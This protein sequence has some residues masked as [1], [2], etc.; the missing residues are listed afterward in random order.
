MKKEGFT[1][2]ELLAVIVILGILAIVIVPTVD[3]SLKDFRKQAYEDQI[4]NIELAAKNWGAD[5]PFDLPENEGD[6]ITVT[7]GS[8]KNGGYVDYRIKNPTTDRYFPN[9][10]LIEVERK[11]KNYEY[12]VIEGS[13]TLEGEYEIDSP[14]LTLKGGSIIY[15]GL[16]ETYEEPGYTARTSSG[17][18]IPDSL[19][20]K[21]IRMNGSEVSSINTDKISTYE[22]EYSVTDRGYTTTVKRQVIVRDMTP[23]VIVVDGH[24]SDF[25]VNHEASSS[26]T[27]PNGTA[28]DNSG[29]AIT[30]TK[31][32]NVI[33]NMVG[34]YKVTYTA[35]DS[36]NN[37]ATLIMTVIVTDTK[38]PT[39]TVSGNPSNWTKNDVTLTINAS[40]SGSGLSTKGAYSFDDGKT[41]Q[42]SNKK[43]FSS[44]QTVHIKVRDNAGNISTR[45]SVVI[46][47][48]D[49]IAPVITVD[50]HTSNYT[51]SHGPR[52]SFT[53]PNG[54]ATDN[55]GE[56]ITVT[57]SGSVTPTVV[58]TYPVTYTAKDSSGNTAT[59]V[60]TVTIVSPTYSGWMTESE[61][62]S[63]GHSTTE[64]GIDKK[65][66]YR[67]TYTTTTSKTESGT[68]SL[69]SA[70][71]NCCW[72][73]PSGTQ[74]FSEA[75]VTQ[76][77][78]TA[79]AKNND[80]D[81]GWRWE[82]YA[83]L[84]SPDTNTW[85]RVCTVQVSGSTCQQVTNSATC[86]VTT[87]KRYTQARVSL[88][89]KHYGYIELQMKQWK[90]VTT[91][92]G[93]TDW[94]DSNTTSAGTV[95][96]TETRTVY[97]Y[98]TN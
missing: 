92:T 12:R 5:H 45:Q 63:A 54:T 72:A 69:V 81:G 22:I 39:F 59:L 15:V 85:D 62:V 38:A 25:T 20:K 52:S 90:V 87:G 58:G 50:G 10:M 56:D 82:G 67:L 33:P 16:G 18:S 13:G 7:L 74:S 78:L 37:V 66:Q 86:N 77:Y 41:W 24:T 57:K 19:V 14:I 89:A 51:I 17:V 53:I 75:Y 8:L 43:T 28:T 42:T 21:T 49:R 60:L 29:E 34:S 80:C 79:T 71:G 2:V 44:N 27:I 47:R 6:V 68:K 73:N 35:K 97:R 88:T 64:F 26:Y 1:L 46:N 4:T 70:T 91:T 30:V 40:D 31:S 11:G 95:T 61:L 36:S 93:V 98:Q 96:K 3:R 9:D 83:E 23:P 32:G 48:I 55:S 84:Y 65:T 94:Q 76:V